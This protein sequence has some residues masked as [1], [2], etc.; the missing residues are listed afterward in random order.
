MRNTVPIVSLELRVDQ[1]QRAH[2]RLKMAFLA[3]CATIV[4]LAASWRQTTDVIR[5]QRLEIVDSTGATVGLISSPLTPIVP[6]DT[7][8]GPPPRSFETMHVLSLTLLAPSLGP[9]ATL[10]LTRDGELVLQDAHGHTAS[11]SARLR[12]IIPR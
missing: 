4:V 3:V 7:A 9:R 1:L 11:F 10:V 8:Q 2:S 12:G 5:T 6:F